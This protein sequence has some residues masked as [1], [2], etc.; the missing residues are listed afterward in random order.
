VDVPKSILSHSMSAICGTLSL[1]PSADVGELRQALGPVRA[2][3]ERHTQRL[4]KFL[5]ERTDWVHKHKA[6]LGRDAPR[7]QLRGRYRTLGML[8]LAIWPL[9]Q[10]ILKWME[11]NPDS[12]PRFAMGQIVRSGKH[13]TAVRDT[14]ER[15]ALLGCGMEGASNPAGASGLVSWWQGKAE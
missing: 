11:A 12:H 7:S 8:V 14:L 6:L 10:A 13:P 2:V 9:R 15:I 3:S 5:H 4:V 1:M